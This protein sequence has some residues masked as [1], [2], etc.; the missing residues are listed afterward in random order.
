[1]RHLYYLNREIDSKI[2]VAI[3]NLIS[4]RDLNDKNTSESKEFGNLISASYRVKR[5]KRPSVSQLSEF[6]KKYKCKLPGTLACIYAKKL[7]AIA[8]Q[9]NNLSFW[10]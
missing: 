3:V 6:F 9:N 2:M 10:V 8:I 1:M 4:S 5:E 7:E